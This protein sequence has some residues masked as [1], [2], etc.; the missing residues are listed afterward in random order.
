MFFCMVVGY[1]DS[2]RITKKLNQTKSS[3]RIRVDV[4][5]PLAL[6][7]ESLTIT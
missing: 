2:F 7:I 4:N 6:Y 5:G 1:I 3:H